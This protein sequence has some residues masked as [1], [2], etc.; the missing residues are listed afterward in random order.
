MLAFDWQRDL[1]AAF[2]DRL[3]S[4]GDPCKRSEIVFQ[5]ELYALP[6]HVAVSCCRVPEHA[7]PESMV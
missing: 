5:S 4:C 7:C 1:A 6:E 3:S 2:S